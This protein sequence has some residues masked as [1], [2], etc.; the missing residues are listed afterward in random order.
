MIAYM[1]RNSHAGN[2]R[3]EASV[4]EQPRGAPGL[5]E[6]LVIS[7]IV[8]LVL[9][10]IVVTY[11]RLPP[12]ELYNTSVGGLRGGLGRALVGAG[13]PFALI[14]LAVV[15]VLANAL[16][17][18]H[19]RL[20]VGLA[21]VAIP[22][23]VTTPFVVEQ[24]DLDAA[25]R[26]VLPATGVVLVGILVVVAVREYGAPP[27]PPARG[28]RVRLV[29][30]VLL[31]LIAIPW[32]FAL[33]GF[34]APDPVYADEPTPGEPLAAV[35]LGT[36][37]GLDGT[38]VALAGLALSRALPSF[39]HRLVTVVT[40]PLLA[41]GV[42]WGIANALQDF[43]L[44]QLWKRGTIGWKPPSVVMPSL[45]WGWLVV[46]CA[47]AVVEILWFRRERAR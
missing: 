31:G 23:C 40:S 21:A 26:N 5:R 44:E 1:A 32:Y 14:A 25:P 24:S 34:Y 7:I 36:H 6:A 20:V 22:L 37:H 41:L 2:A 35:H 10:A 13:F 33:L 18:T 9:L 11:T 3:A 28:D 17:E 19:R 46:L 27:T 45:S 42:A 12:D 30:C 47:A 39:R 15:G 29:L 8:V 38:F 4:P 43:T 16:V